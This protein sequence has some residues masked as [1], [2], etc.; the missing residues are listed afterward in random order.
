MDNRT[1]SNVTRDM[2]WECNWKVL[3]NQTCE[4]DFHLKSNNEGFLS[5]KEAWILAS[6]VYYG[7]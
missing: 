2:G 1:I 5:Q 6:S 7:T 3:E 4:F